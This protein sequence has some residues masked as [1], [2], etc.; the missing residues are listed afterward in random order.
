MNTQHVLIETL[1]PLHIGSGRLLQGNTEY[2]YFANHS[3]VSVVDE[4]KVLSIIGEENL[5]KWIDIIGR[6]DDL[7]D[8]LV[9]RKPNITPA[10]TSKRIVR[11][12]GKRSPGGNQTIREQ[13]FSGNGQPMLPGSSLKGA[14]RTAI[15]NALVRQNP[16]AAQRINDFKEIKEFQDFKS[17]QSKRTVK[18]RGGTL[19]KKYTGPDP[20]HDVFRLLRIGDAHFNETV[21]LLSETLNEKGDGTFEMKNDPHDKV[22]QFIE[23]IPAGAETLFRVQIPSEL[24]ARLNEIK[25]R[26]TA[27]KI[28][29][30]ERMEWTNILADINI[31]TKRLIQNELNRYQSQHLP[32]GALEYLDSLKGMMTGLHNNQCVIRVG[33]GTGYLNM[34]GGWAEQLWRDVANIDFK[35]EMADLAEGVRR[36]ARYN[37]FALPK[38]RKMALGGIPLGFLKLTVFSESEFAAWQAQ[39]AEREAAKLRQA[40]A[41]RIADAEKARLAAEAEAKR[42][43]EERIKAEEAKK[44]KL[45]EG[46]LKQG[47]ELDAEIAKSGKPNKVKVY[48]AGYESKEF[49]LIGYASPEPVGKVVIVKVDQLDK[50]KNLTQIRYSRFK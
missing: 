21:C 32:D 13:I 30:R 39:A 9:K 46:T 35:K 18:Y 20:N 24:K 23:C 8:Y 41:K 28:P 15:F 50:K 6:G 33:F 49:D 3:T 48:A 42:L 1:T 10:D 12:E 25:Y 19:E 34:T 40:E 11:V 47:Q 37:S 5:D 17:G 14:I 4:R 29:H 16:G 7:L 44:P 22:E 26:D 38:S 36:N 45:F 2:L 43:E 27:S 31:N